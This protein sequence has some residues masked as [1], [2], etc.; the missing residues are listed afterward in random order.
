MIEQKYNVKIKNE[1]IIVG[2]I[3]FDMFIKEVNEKLNNGWNLQ[4][5]ISV[6]NKR[7]YQA[8]IRSEEEFEEIKI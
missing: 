6:S 3:Y 4:G 2:N 1:Y 8:M 7:Y 5:G